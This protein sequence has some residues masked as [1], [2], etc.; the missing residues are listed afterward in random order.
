MS[1]WFEFPAEPGGWLRDATIIRCFDAQDK[2]F[3]SV[4]AVTGL[5]WKIKQ[6]DGKDFYA[7]DPKCIPACRYEFTGSYLLSK[8]VEGHRPVLHFQTEGTSDGVG[9]EPFA[10][11]CSPWDPEGKPGV[12][13]SYDE[14]KSR[15]GTCHECPLFSHADGVCTADKAFMPMKAVNAWE[16][17]P[18]GRWAVSTDFDR[19]AFVRR[20]AEDIARATKFADQAEFESEWKE[21]KRA[22]K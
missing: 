21:R 5:R 22:R 3:F 4:D 12:Y 14:W 8:F 9:Y 20:Q 15:M 10:C 1:E 19:E 11:D 13:V 2:E 17:C 7:V 16:S 18:E 6:E